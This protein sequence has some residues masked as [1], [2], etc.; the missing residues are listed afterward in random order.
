MENKMKDEQHTAISEDEMQSWIR[1]WKSQR[2]EEHQLLQ[3]VTGLHRRKGITAAVSWVGLAVWVGWTAYEFS[4]LANWRPGLH[5]APQAKL[6]LALHLVPLL[7]LVFTVTS[8]YRWRRRACSFASSTGV[9]VNELIAA[10]RHELYWHVGG[11]PKALSALVVVSA[12]AVLLARIHSFG[13]DWWTLF[14]LGSAIVVAAV[15]QR[16]RVA[17]VRRELSELEQLVESEGS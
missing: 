9:L 15:V 8:T 3:R 17:R 12:A 5:V 14:L 7:A 16:Y 1:A 6:W 11:L 10:K 4:W 13:E 2:V